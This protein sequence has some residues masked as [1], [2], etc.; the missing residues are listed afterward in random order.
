MSTAFSAAPGQVS[1]NRTQSDVQYA[2]AGGQPL[3]L[4]SKIPDG[5]GPFPAAI[6]VHGGGWV[7]GDRRVEVR[8]L[9]EPL[10]AAGIAWFSIDY[11]LTNDMMQFGVAIEDVASAISYV[12]AH[13]TQYR[14]DPE[15]IALIG[16]SAGGQLAA[17]AALTATP[18][19]R[20][21]AVVAFYTPMDLVDLA[22]NSALIPANVRNS[23]QGTPFENLVLARLSQLSPISNIKADAPPFLLI[24]GTADHL[25]PLSQSAAMCDRMRAAGAACEVY[26]V[27]NAGHGIQWW[28]GSNSRDATGYKAKMVQWLRDQLALRQA[29]FH[30]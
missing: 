17:M 15:R 27:R 16:E 26:P 14:I 6:L 1:S 24:H 29:R 28:D 21:Q 8:P 3:Y 10:T 2:T 25:V 13:A 23:F 18:Q 22:K 12:K 5:P 4:D 19:T 7:R 30:L 11:R 9:F 20:V